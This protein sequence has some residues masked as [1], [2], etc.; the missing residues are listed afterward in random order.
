MAAGTSPAGAQM[1]QMTG[2]GQRAL[3]QIAVEPLAFHVVAEEIDPVVAGI[4]S[5]A[6]Q[7]PTV[8][9]VWIQMPPMVMVRAVVVV[10]AV[11]WP[12]SRAVA[13][14]AG[15]MI[16][17]QNPSFSASLRSAAVPGGENPL[18]GWSIMR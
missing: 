16:D 8:G 15:P 5:H 4:A 10:W 9:Q 17:M 6:G 7:I 3:F 18:C 11:S 14:A 1:G 2:K 13:V 12:I